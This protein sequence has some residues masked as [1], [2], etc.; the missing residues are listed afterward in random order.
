MSF[1]DVYY[2][3]SLVEYIGRL[4]QNKR[5]DVVA[6]IGESGLRH[7]LRAASVNHC[8][9][10]EQVS[11]EVIEEYNIPTGSFDTVSSCRYK[12]PSHLSIGKVY[13]RLV[14]DVG[15]EDSAA[16]LFGILSSPFSEALSDFNSSLYFAPRGELVYHYLNAG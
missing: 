4:T 11:D 6:C 8:L 13:A 15:G 9:S 2:T 12:V 7:L 14:E 16:T 10:F 1:N 3:A 5:S